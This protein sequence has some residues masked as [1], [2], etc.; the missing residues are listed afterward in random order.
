MGP[1]KIRKA[2]ENFS[3]TRRFSH[4]NKSGGE[5]KKLSANFA[6][7]AKFMGQLKAHPERHSQSAIEMYFMS[8]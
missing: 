7:A 6:L 2:A 8:H 5:K 3:R 1:R 4:T